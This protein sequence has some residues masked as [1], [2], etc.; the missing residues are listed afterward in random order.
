MRPPTAQEIRLQQRRE[1]A[2]AALEALPDLS[3]EIRQVAESAAVVHSNDQQVEPEAIEQVALR[4]LESPS[5]RLPGPSEA[6]ASDAVTR[7]VLAHGGDS[8]VPQH[9]FLRQLESPTSRLAGPGASVETDDQAIA[10]A[11]VPT[12][13]EAAIITQSESMRALSASEPASPSSP[14]IEVL[15]ACQSPKS[16]LL[17][18][19]D[20]ARPPAIKFLF[21]PAPD[22]VQLDGGDITEG[23]LASSLAGPTEATLED[24]IHADDHHFEEH[25]AVR[26]DLSNISTTRTTDAASSTSPAEPPLDHD[27]DSEDM[28]I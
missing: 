13:T 8:N 1:H 3:D 21:K 11:V 5:S 20:P 6:V 19:S 28:F 7:P 26:L 18:P 17:G 10:L 4:A 9:E 15:N 12:E 2:K 16:D 22:P 25:N 23:T 14:A 24:G 27:S